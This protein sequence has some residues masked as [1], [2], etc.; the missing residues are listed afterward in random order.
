VDAVPRRIRRG[1]LG[2]CLL[3]LLGQAALTAQTV[4][5]RGFVEGV[6]DV[7]PQ[8]TINDH[9]HLVGDL[10]VREDVFVRPAEWLRMTAGF[11]V[12]ANSHDQVDDDWS[13][14]FW[15]RT[16]RRPPL[17][18]RTLSAT[19]THGPFTLDAGKQFIRWGKTDIV[20][21]TDRFSPRDYLTVIDAPFLAVT[22]VRGTAQVRGYTVEGVWVPR[23]TPSRTPLLTQRWAG[24]AA[25]LAA[26][27]PIVESPT[28]FPEGT[29]AGVRFGHVAGR[30]EYSAS[31]YNG[32]NNLPDFHVSGPATPSGALDLER[33][34]PP[35]RSYGADAVVPLPWF[36]IKAETAYF[37]SSSP[38]ADEYVLY[39]LQLERQRGEWAFVGGYAGEVVTKERSPLSF[40][41]DRGMSRSIV[42]RASYTLDVNRSVNMETAV[43]QNGDGVYAKA[44]YSQARGQHWRATIAGVLLAGD[45]DDFIGQYDHNSHVRLTL[46]YS[47]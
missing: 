15:D 11:E 7:F 6:G 16:D 19:I 4:S 17:S 3:I 8:T 36:S 14:R 20:V 34:F 42:A 37:T 12:R 5:H 25:E 1:R 33:V 44:E 47:Y 29:Q 28:M 9:E 27:V 35:L 41:P 40:S 26:T 13:L 21:P 38:T 2:L 45:S 39:V 24:Q 30:V 46:R 43:R 10:L 31:F 22:G 23:L 32:F 18:V